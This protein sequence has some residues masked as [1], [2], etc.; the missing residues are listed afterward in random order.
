[1]QLLFYIH[2]YKHMLCLYLETISSNS[3][4]TH[5]FF[6][7]NP[8]FLLFYHT[9]FIM[10]F[11]FMCFS[12]STSYETKIYTSWAFTSKYQCT[13]PKKCNLCKFMLM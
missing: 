4:K 6:M 9:D 12:F 2:V 11:F 13:L 8:L 10:F 5:N 1:M 7:H 3:K